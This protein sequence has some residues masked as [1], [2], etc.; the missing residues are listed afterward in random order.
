MTFIELVIQI[1]GLT[2]NLQGDEKIRAKTA[3]ARTLGRQQELSSDAL[4]F[5]RQHVVRSCFPYIILFQIKSVYCTFSH[6]VN[7]F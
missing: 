5:I 1:W 6:C 4:A 3:M 7:G 2:G